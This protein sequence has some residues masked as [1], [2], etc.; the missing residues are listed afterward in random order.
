MG[1]NQKE[2]EIREERKREVFF[3]RLFELSHMYA[4]KVNVQEESSRTSGF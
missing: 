1:F 2:S 3:G 4:S